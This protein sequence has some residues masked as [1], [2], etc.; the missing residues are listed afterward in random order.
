MTGSCPPTARAVVIHE[1]GASLVPEEVPFPQELEPGAAAVRILCCTLCGSDV[2]AW[3]GKMARR[4]GVALPIVMGHEMCGEIVALDDA[5]K[6]DA[7]GR[8]LKVGDRIVWS[9]ASCGHCYECSAMGEPVLCTQRRWNLRQRADQFPYVIA[10]L[11]NFSYVPPG[12]PRLLVSDALDSR[13]AS[14]AT[15]AL[16]TVVRSFARIGGIAAG[17]TV[18]IQGTGALGLFATAIAS[19]EGAGD[20]ICIG[21]PANRL[22]VAREFGA[23]E[24]IDVSVMKEA[25][26]RV[27]AVMER[28]AGK[29]AD[30]VF[31][32]AGAPSATAEGIEMSAKRGRCAVVGTIAASRTPIQAQLIMQRE[33]SIVGSTSG[34]IVELN[35]G[36][37]FLERNASRFG[38]NL[39]FSEA[40]PLEGVMTALSAMSK[41][42]TVKAVVQP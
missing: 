12:A 37:R 21:G 42:D 19:A 5:D 18:V 31:D 36:L 28:T 40:V 24:T 9:E 13:W 26:E 1:W 22:E 41:Y 34:T 29:G 17:Q 15:C 27:A 23:T 25:G 4:G 6:R 20:V 14:A 7:L 3:E 16:K 35:A 33:L 30:V 11:T 10:G 39:M 32:F 38:W 2:H 8:E